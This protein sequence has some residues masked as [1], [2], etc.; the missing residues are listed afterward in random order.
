MTISAVASNDIP[1]IV[2]RQSRYTWRRRLLR[3]W[4]LRP[5][6]FR[7]IVKPKITGLEHIPPDGPT[8]L[9]MNHIGFPDP[10]VVLGAV[11]PRFVVPMSKVENFRHPLFGIIAR[12]WGAY[13]VHRDK[14]DR[15]SLDNT[16]D[17]L[18]AGHAIL[19]APEGTRQPELI[20][21]KD[22]FTFVA[23]KSNAMIVPIGLENTDRVAGNMKRLRRTPIE[24]RFGPAFRF[25]TDGR[26]RIPREEM[27]Q[28]T[29]EAMYQLAKLVDE[30][31]RGFYH[32]L[33][34]ATTNTLE[35]VKNS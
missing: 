26:T 3:D 30:K 19:I 18:N 6:G 14:I 32:D 34:H 25:K 22:G 15:Q 1:L 27:R 17:L 29:Q 13:P 5:V 4:L 16:L 33:S 2:Q 20:Q 23:V 35:F 24:I 12:L 8:L 7:V 28:M 21:A 31:R 10:V 9:V 11:K